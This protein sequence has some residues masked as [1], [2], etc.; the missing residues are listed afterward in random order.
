MK[1]FSFTIL[2]LISGVLVLSAQTNAST[3]AVDEI[4]ALVT[5][6]APP[7]AKPARGPTTIES[8]SVDFDLAGHT[9]TYC[10]DV[11]VDDPQM[12]LRCEWLLASLPQGGGHVTNIVAETNVVIDFTDDKGKTNHATSD[13]AVYFYNVQNGVTNETVTLTGHAKVENDQG[14]LTGEPIIWNRATGH[15]T[16]NNGKTIFRQTV[17]GS[18]T[19]SPMTNNFSPPK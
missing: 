11:R 19:N 12:K 13:K 8:D 10:G 7:A 18:A 1:F 2:F 15:V 3:N 16:A 6:N 9:A 17:T 5:T 14:W 4:L